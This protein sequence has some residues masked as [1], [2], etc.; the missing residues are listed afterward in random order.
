MGGLNVPL[1]QVSLL[2]VD[3]GLTL[4]CFIV[5]LSLSLSLF[6]PVRAGRLRPIRAKRGSQDGRVQPIRSEVSLPSGFS[7]SAKISLIEHDFT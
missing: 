3:A 5:S 2:G 7:L 4:F 6:L 1:C